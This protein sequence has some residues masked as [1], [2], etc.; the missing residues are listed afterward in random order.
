MLIAVDYLR[1]SS[2]NQ[3]EESIFAQRRAIEEYADKNGIHIIKE[4]VDEAQSAQNDD[5][6]NF[7]KMMDDN[8]IG[9]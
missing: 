4:Y 8:I 9:G 1:Y 5:R 3:R 6:P 2:E 7:L